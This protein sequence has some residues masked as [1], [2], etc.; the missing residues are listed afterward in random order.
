VT[1]S[2]TREP[3]ES[4]RT[5]PACGGWNAHD[6]TH[7]SRCAEGLDRDYD[8][9]FSL[10]FSAEEC[11]NCGRV[12]PTSPC[13]HCGADVAQVNKT[14]DLALARQKAF[15]KLLARAEE[16]QAR[17][18]ELPQPHIPVA[19]DQYGAAVADSRVLRR[20]GVLL[21]SLH[22]LDELGFNDQKT[23]GT[24]ARKRL[25][26]L[27]A[28]L[29][30]IYK[31]TEQ[32][33][34]FRA[35]SDE[36][37]RV[38]TALIATGSYI[39][40]VVVTLLRALSALSPEE[41]VPLQVRFQELLANY[42]Y[43]NEFTAAL[44]A[45]EELPVGD[46][47]QRVS[48]ALGTD[49]VVADDLGLLDPARMLSAFAGGD[50]PFTPLAR[51]CARYLSHLGAVDPESVGP[52]GAALALGAFG[53][54]VLD[55]P[56]AAHGIARLVVDLLT[57]AGA[58]DPHATAALFT[59]TF[60]EGPRIFAA[61]KR[62]HDDLYYLAAGLARDEDDVVGRLV[63]T[64]R[65]LA[66]SSFRSYLWLVVDAQEIV[67]GRKRSPVDRAP[68]LGELEQR[69]EGREDDL[70]KSLLRAV[71]RVLRNADAHEDFRLNAETRE[72]VL[73]GRRLT[74]DRFERKLERLVSASLALDAAFTCRAYETGNLETVPEWLTAGEAPYASELLTRAFLGAYGI[75]LVGLRLDDDLTLLVAWDS[76]DRVQALAPLCAV[77]QLFPRTRRL[78]LQ[79]DADGDP[80]IAAETGAFRAFADAGEAVKNLAVLAPLYSAGIEAGRD[81]EATAED[82]LA[83]AIVLIV[84]TDV[85]RLKIALGVG[86]PA[87]LVTLEER[88]AYVI[89]F[90]RE[91]SLA[92]SPKAEAAVSA[93]NSAKV[94][95]MFARRGD[96]AAIQRMTKALSRA[97]TW[98]DAR[99]C[100]WPPI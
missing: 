12:T 46:V 79:A 32:I 31:E 99:G 68:M 48:L 65:R 34:W 33:A 15:A 35:P 39:T 49:V 76:P 14:S 96:S 28:A 67:A 100:R 58:K 43:E 63:D 95:S 82:F 13:V 16:L 66:E 19:P 62:I 93:L 37:A 77:A 6:S 75:E 53:L 18:D 21:R 61:A 3:R 24:T 83:L 98:A 81:Q 23:I 80:L 92:L 84:A 51:S 87:P 25:E 73:D 85:P 10:V 74:L 17:Y 41:V 72:I 26:R 38:R 9:S 30:G 40:E 90:V 44:A 86:N 20:A 97:A 88:L 7:C 47:N 69:L 52:E 55:R 59:R 1:Q 94:A 27:V 22:R 50:D 78:V 70:S 36:V 4:F 42:P 91:R 54:I 89:S 2:D 5:C 56:L 8:I 57:Q 71:D 29:E 64:Y 60:G 45:L 11:Q